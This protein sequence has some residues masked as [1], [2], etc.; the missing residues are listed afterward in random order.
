MNISIVP[1][2]FRAFSTLTAEFTEAPL[3]HL[4]V[5]LANTS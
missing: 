4:Y 5:L 2:E 3:L 1:A